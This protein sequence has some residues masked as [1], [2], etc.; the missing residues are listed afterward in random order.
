MIPQISASTTLAGCPSACGCLFGPDHR[1]EALVVEHQELG[2]PVDARWGTASSDRCSSW[3][4]GSG[5][6]RRSDRAASRA[7]RSSEREAHL[8]GAGEKSVVGC[9]IVGDRGRPMR[10]AHVL[11]PFDSP[12]CGTGSPSANWRPTVAYLPKPN[13]PGGGAA[14]VE[15]PRLCVSLRGSGIGARPS[16]RRAPTGYRRRVGFVAVTFEPR[17]GAGASSSSSSASLDAPRRRPPG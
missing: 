8:A 11:S 12:L 4:A 16:K 10:F 5:A 14:L 6:S 3:S 17:F 15:T 13:I 9:V 7:N 2:A 1:H